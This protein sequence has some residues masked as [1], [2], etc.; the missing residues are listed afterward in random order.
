M[1]EKHL[2]TEAPTKGVAIRDSIVFLFYFILLATSFKRLSYRKSRSCGLKLIVVIEIE[3]KIQTLRKCRSSSRAIIAMNKMK[4]M[5]SRRPIEN[6]AIH[7]SKKLKK[8]Y[9]RL[10]Y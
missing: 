5:T 1:A 3:N 4:M 7:T 10:Q 2:R 6:H 9:Y 8:D